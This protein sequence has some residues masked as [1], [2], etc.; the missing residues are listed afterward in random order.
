ME[1][2]I[3]KVRRGIARVHIG[4]SWAMDF[5]FNCMKYLK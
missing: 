3:G 5:G 1:N 4:T 2:M